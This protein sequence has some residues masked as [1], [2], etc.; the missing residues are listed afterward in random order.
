MAK[1]RFKKVMGWLHLWLGLISGTVLILVAISGCILSFEAELEPVLFKERHFVKTFPNRLSAD[2]L[3]LIAN[4]VYP[5]K[6]TSKLI[7]NAEPD[8]SAEARIGKGPE[9]K[10]VYI[11]PYTGKVL[12]KGLF[13]KQFFRVVRNVHRYLL[14]GETGKAIT[15]FSCII[16]LFLSISG[17]VIWWPANKSA[18]KQRFKIKWNAKSKRLNWDLHAV[19]G[20]YLSFFLILITLTGIVMSY[21]WAENL[22]YKLADGKV[23]K[24]LTPK[25]L[26]RIKQ[27][28][29]GVLQKIEDSMN[30]LYPNA[31]R[32]NFNIPPKGGLAIMGQKES[33]QLPPGCTDAAYFDSKTGQLIKQQPFAA[34]SLGTKIKKY[35]L[36]LHSG[37]IYGWGTKILAFAVSLFTVSLPVTGFLIWLGKRKK[38]KKPLAIKHTSKKLATV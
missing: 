18:I 37:S 25:N 9:M 26:V 3:L 30:A 23:Q 22:I 1:N 6:K 19:T 29:P 21:D 17:I 33:E 27:A 7:I 13:Q 2:S 8:R 16:C 28:K 34:V 20:F 36:P 14:L 5:G 31:G 38:K 32:L 24:E 15:G 11:D 4:S 35:V 12:Y 10:V